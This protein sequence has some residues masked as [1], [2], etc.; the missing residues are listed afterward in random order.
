[1]K[2]RDCKFL[3][4][5]KIFSEN[6]SPSVRCSAGHWDSVASREWYSYDESQLNRGPVRRFGE[7]C[8]EGRLK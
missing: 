2:C 6:G 7:N 3:E 8:L 4:Q 1:M 5:S